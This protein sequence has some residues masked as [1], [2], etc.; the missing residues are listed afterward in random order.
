[1]CT[2]FQHQGPLVVFEQLAGCTLTCRQQQPWCSVHVWVLTGNC[3][4]VDLCGEQVG[5]QP[6]AVIRTIF[7]PLPANQ[8]ECAVA[9]FGSSS[10]A[11]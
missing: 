6:C 1:M 3:F 8:L 11:T 2:A 7:C 10:S 5:F 4:H 9:C